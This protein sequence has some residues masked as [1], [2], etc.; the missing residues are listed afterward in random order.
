VPPAAKGFTVSAHGNR[1]IDLGTRFGV[2]AMLRDAIQLHVFEGKVKAQTAGAGTKTLAG[3][4]ALEV[5]AVAFRSRPIEVA[6]QRFL[7]DWG[8]V[9]R[10]PETSG[11]VK[12]LMRPPGH[13]CVG[14]L[15]SN[16]TVF[17]IPERKNVVLSADLSVAATVPGRYERFDGKYPVRKGTRVD[18]YLLHA[19]RVGWFDADSIVKPSPENL[20]YEGSIR[21]A[22]PIVG[23]I[24]NKGMLQTT[25][26]ELGLPGQYYTIHD[27]RQIGLTG[28]RLETTAGDEPRDVFTI[29]GDRRTLHLRIRLKK[30]YDNIRVL[31]QSA[32]AKALDGQNR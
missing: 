7:L 17:A 25:D 16:D 13:V 21:F 5:D 10:L 14:S 29:G 28:T 1:F 3:N 6:P 23:V 8:K 30:H 32:P 20:V 26:A 27:A 11:A 31:V 24:A 2:D 9:N 15:E 4:E 18:S 19:D 12:L 22:Q